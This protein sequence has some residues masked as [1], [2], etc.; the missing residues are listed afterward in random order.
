VT[1]QVNIFEAIAAHDTQKV[2]DLLAAQPELVNARNEQ[3][4][5][6]LLLALYSDF[7]DICDELLA[8]KPEL[9]VFEA[10]A[11]G[12]TTRVRELLQ[13]DPRLLNFF[14]H[15]GWTPLHLAVYFGHRDTAEELLDLGADL[16]AV[17]QNSS[18]VMPLHSALARGRIELALLLIDRGADVTAP[19]LTHGYTPLHYAAAVGSEEAV[20][21]LLDAGADP[22][23]AA[24]DGKLPADMATDKGH[25]AVADLLRSLS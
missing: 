7:T 14:S 20:R 3:G 24:L 1:A 23:V 21:K 15:D 25:T 8:A 10:A 4:D 13:D 2:R 11:L 17:S 6:P 16:H 12:N 19:Q 22:S 18:T 9:S 5:S